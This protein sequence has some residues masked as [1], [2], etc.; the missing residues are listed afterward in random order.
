MCDLVART[1]RH[2]QRYESGCR[3]VAGYA[4][5]LFFVPFILGYRARRSRDGDSLLLVT[6]GYDDCLS[7]LGFCDSVGYCLCCAWAIH[8]D[9]ELLSFSLSFPLLCPAI[10]WSLLLLYMRGVCSFVCSIAFQCPKR[11]TTCGNL[12][13][14]NHFYRLA[15]AFSG[16]NVSS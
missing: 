8:V 9:Y 4:R 16:F 11:S 6:L 13:S 5:F 10:L 3:L 7:K 15:R 12:E 14:R 1:G 2:Q